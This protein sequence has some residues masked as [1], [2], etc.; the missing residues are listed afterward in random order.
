MDEPV[1]KTGLTAVL[2]LGLAL[3]GLSALQ[4]IAVLGLAGASRLRA[5]R[6]K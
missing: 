1:G 2:L 3:V 6:A 5:D 4:T